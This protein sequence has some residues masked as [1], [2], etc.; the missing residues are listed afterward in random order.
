MAVDLLV[1]REETAHR[2]RADIERLNDS[3]LADLLMRIVEF[4]ETTAWMLRMVNH[5]SD[6]G[7][8]A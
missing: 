3:S 5:G 2:P 1:R 4:H 8:V 7:R 6:P